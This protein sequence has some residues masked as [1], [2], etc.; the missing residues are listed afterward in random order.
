MIA[1]S[2]RDH[3]QVLCSVTFVKKPFLLRRSFEMFRRQYDFRFSVLFSIKNVRIY[4]ENTAHPQIVSVGTLNFGIFDHFSTW[5]RGPTVLAS[6]Y[7]PP[8]FSARPELIANGRFFRS[9]RYHVAD[10][11]PNVRAFP[12]RQ[13]STELYGWGVR[14]GRARVVQTATFQT[15]RARTLFVLPHGDIG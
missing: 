10:N 5:T 3:T 13:F 14:R 4:H 9:I 2:S 15:K 8:P 11:G 1:V 12:R 6:D 7:P